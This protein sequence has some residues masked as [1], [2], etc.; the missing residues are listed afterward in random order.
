MQLKPLN[1][2][3]FTN[4]PTQFPLISVTC[5]FPRPKP[6]VSPAIVS[7]RETII[8]RPVKFLVVFRAPLGSRARRQTADG[9]RC[10]KRFRRCRE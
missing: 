5:R 4:F 9:H 1:R 6:L 7:L 3:P 10:P 2:S 8:H